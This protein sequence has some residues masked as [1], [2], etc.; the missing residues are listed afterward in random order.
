MSNAAS[1]HHQIE[2]PRPNRLHV[3]KRVSV[4]NLPFKQKR[5]GRQVDVG[6][7]A[8]INTASRQKRGGTYVVEKDPRTNLPQSSPWQ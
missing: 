5:Y 8:D 4:Q 1:C 6:V 3:P 2:I 7:R